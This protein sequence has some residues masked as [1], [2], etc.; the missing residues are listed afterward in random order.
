MNFRERE[1]KIAYI[2]EATMCIAIGTFIG[3]I[4]YQLFLYFKIAI[5]GWNLGL[6]FAPLV[7]GYAETLLANKIIGEGIGA[8][9]AFI[10]FAYTTF[11]S[12]I[13]K[14]P[15]LGFNF[16]TIG[17]LAVILQAAF[18]T[19]VNFIL[20]TVG[21]GILS[22]FLGIFKRITTF[23]HNKLEYAYYKY[24]LKKPHEIRIETV[25]P[26]DEMRSNEIINKLDFYFITSTDIP[27]GRLIN[28]GQFHATVILEKD[29]RLVHTKQEKIEL[30]TLN[31]FKQSKDQCLIKLAKS[32]KSA[33][34]NGV[35]DLDIEYGLIG[36]GGDSYQ[37]TAMGMG[38]YLE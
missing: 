25:E 37:I 36:L 1:V 16:I 26:F 30:V 20:L 2:K 27:K 17:S 4:V 32:I 31:H 22:Y 34:G 14:N 10:L 6:I 12:F 21:M 23:F 8:I 24:I 15:S 29:K 11:Y 7:A 28:L 35:I 3:L 9:S 5:F 38:V 13:L 33:G 19:A 18:P